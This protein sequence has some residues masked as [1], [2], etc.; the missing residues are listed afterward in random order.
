[1]NATQW[2]AFQNELEKIKIAKGYSSKA[3]TAEFSK[4]PHIVA[5]SEIKLSDYL[6]RKGLTS[7]AF[8]KGFSK[9]PHVVAPA[10][11]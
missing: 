8:T 3:F 6:T 9:G 2:V 5:P 11:P 1:M 10:T 4:G 7:K